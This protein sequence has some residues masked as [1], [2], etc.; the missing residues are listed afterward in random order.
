MSAL[1]VALRTGHRDL[2]SLLTYN[3]ATANANILG[4]AAVFGGAR[5]AKRASEI[6]NNSARASAAPD[7]SA[8]LEMPVAK[9]APADMPITA[10]L[11][12][13]SSSQSSVV[14]FKRA[15]LQSLRVMCDEGTIT[16][17]EFDYMRRDG[18][19]LPHL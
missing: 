14:C 17:A 11:S 19:G 12:S 6:I 9:K 1:A 16:E 3:S 15:E 2:Q 7:T 18:L 4:S 13:T 10:A 5:G 8:V